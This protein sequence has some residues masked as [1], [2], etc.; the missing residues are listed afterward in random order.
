MRPLKEY[1]E[2]IKSIAR[3]AA[4]NSKI[5]GGHVSWAFMVIGVFFTVTQ[6]YAL[7]HRGM[8]DNV[9]WRGWVDAAAALPVLLMEGSALALVY[10]R[11]TCLRLDS[12]VGQRFARHC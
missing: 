11:H 7:C 6:T 2:E 8:E 3:D 9:L 10:G 12:D 1:L 5:K 4:K